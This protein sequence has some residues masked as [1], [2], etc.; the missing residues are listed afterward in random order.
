MEG[1]KE[2]KLLYAQPA[3]GTDPRFTIGIAQRPGASNSVP[4]GKNTRGQALRC[5]TG[6]A[7]R[8][9]ASNSASRGQAR[10]QAQPQTVGRENILEKEAKDGHKIRIVTAKEF[11]EV[12][13][14]G[15]INITTSRQLLIEIAKSEN[16][17][18]DYDLLDFRDTQW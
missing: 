13:P 18:I 17:L 3:V 15:E 6:I 14:D 5:A 7:P 11:I 9:D 4:P 1:M 2:R 16:H 10:G 8:P 12:T